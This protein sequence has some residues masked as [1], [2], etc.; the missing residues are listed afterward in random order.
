MEALDSQNGNNQ[1]LI[2]TP[3]PLHPV[4]SHRRHH[5]TPSCSSQGLSSIVLHQHAQSRLSQIPGTCCF[6]VSTALPWLRPPLSPAWS[7]ATVSRLARR[8]RFASLDPF[9]AGSQV[10]DHLGFWLAALSNSSTVTQ[11]K[12]VYSLSVTVQR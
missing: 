2:R 1:H 9:S 5:H 8:V 10:I 11:I 6:S 4:P 3:S 7:T 12:Q